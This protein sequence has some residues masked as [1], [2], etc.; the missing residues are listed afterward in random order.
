MVSVNSVSNNNQQNPSVAKKVG[1][2]IAGTIA[3]WEAQPYIRKAL[4][5]PIYKSIVSGIESVRGNEFK[6][7]I[8][9]ALKVSGLD[10]IDFKVIDLNEQ[11][12][13]SVKK[14]LKIPEE[15]KSLFKRIKNHILH[16]PPSFVSGLDAIV[17]GNNAVCVPSQKF[18]LCNLE[19]ASV[20]FF[21]E[22]SHMLHA[23]SSNP[24][25][26]GLHK[27]RIVTHF[28]V[29]CA[30]LGA[31]FVEKNQEKS[32]KYDMDPFLKQHC[33]LIAS[34]MTLPVLAEETLANIDAIKLAKASGVKGDL[35]K[36]VHKMGALSTASY[37]AS[38]VMTGLSVYL[39]SK[40]KDFITSMGK[41]KVDKE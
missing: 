3:G 34:V 8:N 16:N 39:A 21:H 17:Q 13:E 41:P 31:V 9:D 1:F 4:N 37:L 7:F 11:N 27:S 26:S 5:I 25:V 14:E 35:L 38:T 10:K 23:S 18:T 32:F 6:P 20:S 40:M 30:T 24:L 22:A 36:K 29:I 33:G 12:L 2:S 28:G 19:K 15:P